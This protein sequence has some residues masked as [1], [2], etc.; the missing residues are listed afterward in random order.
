MKRPVCFGIALAA[1]ILLLTFIV[2][3]ELIKL[4]P[5]RGNS[6]PGQEMVARLVSVASEAPITPIVQIVKQGRS[7]TMVCPKGTLS[8]NGIGVIYS[9][10]EWVVMEAPRQFPAYLAGIRV[11][12]QLLN[13][14]PETKMTI[15]KPMEIRTRRN[16]VEID[17]T[18]TPLKICYRDK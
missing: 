12:D 10:F 2:R 9:Y 7:P 13:V 18:I 8:Y 14:T 11:G 17:Y 4:Q 15:G 16:G 3:A 1:H 6:G 5:Q